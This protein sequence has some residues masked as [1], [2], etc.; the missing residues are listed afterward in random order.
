MSTHP[1]IPLFV[2]D[3]EAA[4]AHLTVEEDGAYSR[5]LRLC[6]RT[7]GCSI[8]NDP[9]WISRKI[10]IPAAD[11]ERVVQPVLDEFFTVARGRLFQRRLKA[12]Y[13]DISRKKSA[14]VK[15]GQKGGAAKAM[16]THDIDPS[17][18]SDLPLHTRAF[19]YPDPYP[20]K[21]EKI[22]VELP[23]QLPESGKAAARSKGSRL[24]A[25]WKP[26]AS[27]L[28]YAAEKGFAESGIERIAENFRDY[29]IAAAGAKGV[30]LDWDAAWRTWVRN[31][32]DRRGGPAP[33]ARKQVD[34]C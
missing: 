13:D 34:W 20:E 5:L 32:R 7:P 23:L 31:E 6:W 24:R 3:Y 11:F 2:D 10:R 26:S 17:N 15:A 21:E 1:F 14:R 29:W 9:S 22:D 4:T 8:P 30:K 18:A 25:D 16:K 19:P 27:N 28:A 12:E 33:I